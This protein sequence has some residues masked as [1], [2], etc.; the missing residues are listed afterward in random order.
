VS[1]AGKKQ[2]PS[3]ITKANRTLKAFKNDPAA[4]DLLQRAKPIF[5]ILLLDDPWGS[6]IGRHNELAHDALLTVME[7]LET[8]TP[9]QEYNITDDMIGTVHIL[10]PNPITQSIDLSITCCSFVML[11]LD[12]GIISRLLRVQ[13]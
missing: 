8:Q 12:L 4:H 2:K 1:K 13:R 5:H 6:G 11:S 3:D 9:G 10:H 7:E